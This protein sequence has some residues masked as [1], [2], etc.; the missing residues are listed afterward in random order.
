MNINHKRL[1]D[2]A[3]DIADVIRDVTA[4]SGI[5]QEQAAKAVEIAAL[6]QIKDE[7][8]NIDYELQDL[9]VTASLLE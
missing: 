2:D 4:D 7:L 8:D 5:S 6:L 3:C 1:Y 9:S